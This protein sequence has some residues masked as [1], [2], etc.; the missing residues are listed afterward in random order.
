MHSWPRRKS[1][2]QQRG[3]VG[4]SGFGF[5]LVRFPEFPGR[6]GMVTVGPTGCVKFTDS[7]NWM[8]GKLEP[9]NHGFI[10]GFWTFG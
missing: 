2:L 10:Y 7:Q 8:M 4:R 9:E 6:L 1:D 3:A 5:D